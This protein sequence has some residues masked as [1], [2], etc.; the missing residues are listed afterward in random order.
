M[1][2]LD[3]LWWSGSSVLYKSSVDLDI[4]KKKSCSINLSS[5]VVRELSLLLLVLL[6]ASVA[7]YVVLAVQYSGL[8]P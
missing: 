4:F 1:G 2:R 5:P 7:S 6:L 3:L 8:V